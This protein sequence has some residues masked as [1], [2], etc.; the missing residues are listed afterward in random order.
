MVGL[1]GV[2]SYRAIFRVGFCPAPL[3]GR[4]GVKWISD[5]ER[6]RE[7]ERDVLYTDR[8]RHTHKQ[9]DSKK[10]SFL[11]NF[12]LCESTLVATDNNRLFLID[13]EIQIDRLVL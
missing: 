13:I 11:F 10:F 1:G 3:V 9:T 6:E 12:I 5:R 7:R 8:E 2:L 4:Q